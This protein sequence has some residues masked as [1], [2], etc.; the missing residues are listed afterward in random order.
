MW[1]QASGHHPSNPR[2]PDIPVYIS[3]AKYMFNIS[4][5]KLTKYKTHSGIDF[6]GECRFPASKS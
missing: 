6:L 5:L 1:E 2:Q 3:L 4:T